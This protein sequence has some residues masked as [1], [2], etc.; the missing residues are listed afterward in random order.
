MSIHDDAFCQGVAKVLQGESQKAATYVTHGTSLGTLREKMVGNFIRHETPERFKVETGL[1]RSQ[2]KQITSRQCDILVHEPWDE[3]PLYRYEDFVIVNAS[4]SRAVIEV[5]SNFTKEHF[6]SMLKINASVK[7]FELIS[8]GKSRTPVLAYGLEG[9]TGETLAEYL[10]EDLSSQRFQEEGLEGSDVPKHLNW[11]DCIAIQR[12]N[13]IGFRPSY[14]FPNR[15]Q[16]NWPYCFCILDLTK[17]AQEPK[18]PADGIETGI[19]INLYDINIR[20]EIEKL[21][22]DTLYRWFNE[23]PLL[24]EGKIWIHPDGTINH[25]NIPFVDS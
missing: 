8:G 11:P 15:A 23:M 14:S 17:A 20:N 22:T 5:K 1:I 3:A 2:I 24:D 25:G 19:F 18:P 10:T 21:T 4:A 16:E 7:I 6:A 13:I 9:P 12:R